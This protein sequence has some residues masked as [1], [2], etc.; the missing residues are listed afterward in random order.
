VL[1]KKNRCHCGVKIQDHD[2]KLIEDFFK[3]E[4][5]TRKLFKAKESMRAVNKQEICSR[6]TIDDLKK[7]M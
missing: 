3:D 5:F 7:L 6:F 1:F 4:V 2:P